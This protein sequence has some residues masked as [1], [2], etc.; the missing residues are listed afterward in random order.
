M[1]PI[2][3]V[4]LTIH[5]SS[6]WVM[7]WKFVANGMD[8][9]I[10]RTCAKVVLILC[11][12]FFLHRKCCADPQS[13]SLY[14]QLFYPAA[15][16]SAFVWLP[17]NQS[18]SNYP[19]AQDAELRKHTLGIFSHPGGIHSLKELQLTISH[20]REMYQRI[21]PIIQNCFLPIERV[22]LNSWFQKRFTVGWFCH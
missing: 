12:N 5:N 7:P 6:L 11:R 15:M 16:L 3:E 22:S 1:Q 21:A 2:V 8:L 19:T 18:V 20:F 4:V 17:L 13:L 10:G 9:A 14:L